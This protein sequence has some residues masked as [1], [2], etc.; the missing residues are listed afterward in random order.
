[1]ELMCTCA[2]RNHIL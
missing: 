1:M 2:T